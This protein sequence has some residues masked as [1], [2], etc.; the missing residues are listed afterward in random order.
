MS[1]EVVGAIDKNNKPLVQLRFDNEYTYT[2]DAKQA[3]ELAK[4]IEQAAQE[5]R[6][7]TEKVRFSA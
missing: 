5:I 7:K 3:R 4:V 6:L 2:L 1:V